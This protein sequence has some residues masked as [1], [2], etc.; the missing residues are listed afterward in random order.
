MRKKKADG[1]TNREQ[2]AAGE[3]RGR[4]EER[5][6]RTVDSRRKRIS[7]RPITMPPETRQKSFQ[8]KRRDRKARLLRRLK[9]PFTYR[10]KTRRRWRRAEKKD[11]DAICKTPVG[12]GRAM[13]IEEVEEGE[14]RWQK[15]KSREGKFR[16]CLRQP[17]G[18]QRL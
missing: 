3:R 17:R 4:R 2:G 14:R 8:V 5:R 16:Y 13:V 1:K 6:F 9:V 15:S 7:M 11:A 18:T 12:E 10:A